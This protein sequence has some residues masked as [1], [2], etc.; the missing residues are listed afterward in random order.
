MLFDYTGVTPTSLQADLELA[1][2]TANKLVDSIVAADGSRTFDNT[3]APWVRASEVVA[4]AYGHGPFLGHGSP[5]EDVR[6]I[7]RR[8]EE[9]LSKWAVELTFRDDL[10]AAVAEFASSEEG[11][12]LT[13]EEGRLVDQTMRDFR[14]AGHELAGEP[15][16]E[17]KQLN[18]RLVELGVIFATNIAEF[19]DFLV[20][21]RADIS[22]LPDSYAE[23]LKPGEKE[24]T[25]CVS[26]AYPDVVPFMDNVSNRELREALSR[27]FT[28]RAAELNRPILQEAVDI[29]QRIADIFGVPSWAHHSMQV[30]MAKHPEAV[31]D[32][33][34]SLVPSLTALGHDEKARMT[35]MLEADTG[36]KEMHSW[37]WRYYHSKLRREQYG[38]DALEVANYLPLE[39]A[40]QGMLD[41]TQEMFGV[42]YEQI[43]P[44]NAWHEDVTLWKVN[45]T[46]S[47]EHIGHF[48]M[49]LFPREGKFSHAAA[50]DLVPA[51]EGPDGW[52]HPVSAIL[53]NFPKPTPD[54][55]GLLTHED[56]LTLFHE[57]GHILHMTFSQAR[58]I[59]FSGAGTEWDFVEAPSQIMEH[60]CW[61]PQILQRFA[62]HHETGE[63]MPTELVEQIQTARYVNE[64]L[65]KLRQVTYGMVD[66][67]LH[68][69]NRPDSLDE[70][71][72]K[73]TE[74]S[75]FPLAE[76]TFFLGS[77]GH[78][79]GY[80]AG[81]YGYLWAEVFGD[82]MFSRFEK[83]GIDNPA[84]G[85]DYRKYVL[86][87]NGTK[88][89]TELVT[90]FLGR[91]PSSDAFL[92][93]LGIS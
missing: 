51:H 77:F 38:V 64:A 18:E 68:G 37:D 72:A 27:K 42:T 63:P 41:L 48:Y 7:A 5:E 49:D 26:M 46:A 33:Y 22:D 34:D 52:V 45:D 58:M 23:G 15:R 40:V 16:A 65:A 70:A 47:G 92:G 14:M 74:F 53:A 61:K 76:D 84:V 79:F 21:T 78:M 43:E 86:E 30:K 17:L 83:D 60:W 3:I 25:F 13:G 4:I 24:G 50:W 19:E 69:P 89:A 57:F 66:M 87:P 71:L 6:N 29:R 59:R 62:F 80:D 28:N 36:D 8:M 11:V 2:D 73:A 54:R 91:A 12:S 85:M 82:D 20:V 39:R 88:D 90:D 93:N 32:F 35:A 55:P 44:T 10:Y 81:Y 75:L 9:V 56:L 1:L 67:Y 31:F